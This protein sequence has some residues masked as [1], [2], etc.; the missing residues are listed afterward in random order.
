MTTAVANFNVGL[1]MW[2]LF[3]IFLLFM[4]VNDN[5]VAVANTAHVED[6]VVVVAAAVACHCQCWCHW[7]LDF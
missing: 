6:G 7:S 3:L 1:L 2:L 4:T 5:V